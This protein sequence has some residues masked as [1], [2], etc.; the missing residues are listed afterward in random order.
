M[1]AAPITSKKNFSLWSSA[2][3]K[4]IPETVVE[5]SA[6]AS[7]ACKVA[8]QNDVS[9]MITLLILKRRRVMKC[10]CFYEPIRIGVL[11]AIAE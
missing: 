2:G 6:A 1:V 11:S 10:G 3:P 8:Y 7:E 5:A 4:D 9:P